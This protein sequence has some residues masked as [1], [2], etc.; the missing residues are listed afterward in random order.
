MSFTRDPDYG[1]VKPIL[2]TVSYGVWA[3]APLSDRL[4][5]CDSRKA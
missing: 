1:L 5:S 2:A 3:S 4:S